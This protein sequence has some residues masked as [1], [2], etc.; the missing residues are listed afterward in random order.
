MFLV[1][2]LFPRPGYDRPPGRQAGCISGYGRPPERQVG[3]GVW[4]GTITPIFPDRGTEQNENEI[5]TEWRGPASTGLHVIC[6]AVSPVSLF[7]SYPLDTGRL[8]DVVE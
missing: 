5:G 3:C 4:E 6:T 2:A 7:M 8:W 1:K